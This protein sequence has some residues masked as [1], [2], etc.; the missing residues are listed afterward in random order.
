MTA[1]SVLLQS[2]GAKRVELRG[3]WVHYLVTARNSKGCS[4]FEFDVAPGFDTGVHYHT[5]IEEFFYVLEGELD[6]RSGNQLV[7]AEPGTFVFVSP[8]T[9]H[10]IANV[11]KQPSTHVARM[12]PAGSRR[13]L[14]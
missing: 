6:L 2:G 8:G 11:R 4:L 9:T 1:A 14:Q 12:S 10:S 7:H 5:K 3:S 13:L